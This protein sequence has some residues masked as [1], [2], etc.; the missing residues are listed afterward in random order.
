MPIPLGSDSLA[1]SDNKFGETGGGRKST[2]CKCLESV[3]HG[4]K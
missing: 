3:R 2:I 4:G 1:G